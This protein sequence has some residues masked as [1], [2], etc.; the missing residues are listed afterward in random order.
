[1]HSSATV[2]ICE[3]EQA[4]IEESV[5]HE[6]LEEE[7]GEHVQDSSYVK[8][9]TVNDFTS[10]HEQSDKNTRSA[11]DDCV[12]INTPNN[13]HLVTEQRKNGSMNQNAHP[14]ENV[15]TSVLRNTD[16]SVLRNTDTNVLRNTDTSI[17]SAF[18]LLA[19]TLQEGF[20]LP[21]PELLRFS[22]S[23]LEYC[24]FVNN[25]ETNID[26]KVRDDRLRLS[27]LI[28]YCDGEAK[29]AIEDCV[30]LSP[31]EGY[32][33]ARDILYSRYGRPH[34][35]ARTYV[36]KI[37]N[38]HSLKAS[39][40]N[41]LSDLALEMRKCEITL[42][43]LGFKSDI[44]N[45]DNL[46]RIVRRLPMHVRGK[47]VDIAHSITESGREPGF[48]DLVKFVE[49]KARIATSLY[50]LDL[51]NEKSHGKIVEDRTFKSKPSPAPR[52]NNA[53]SFAT[54]SAVNN[55]MYKPSRKCYCCSGSC[56]DLASC[57]KFTA[58]NLNDR[59]QF[60]K[61]NRLCFNCLKGKHFSNVCRK[62][63]G[64]NVTECKS[65]HHFLLHSWVDSKSDHT[66][67]QSVVNCATK[68]GSY[69][70]NCL[71]IIPVLVRGK[72]GTYCKTYA[73]LDE[74]ADQTLCD[75][76]LLKML[77]LTSKPV[78]FKM[79]TASSSGIIVEGQEVE[80]HVQP[81]SGGNDVTL[82]KVWSVKSLPVSTRS[83]A[84]NADI[85]DLPY[86]SKI[87]TPEIDSSSVMLLI[88]TDAPQAHIPLE[89][90]SGRHDQPYAIKTQLG[91]AVRGPVT[92]TTTQKSANVNFQQ[93]ADVLLQQQLEKMWTT[94]FDDKVK[95]E[96]NSMSLEDKKALNTM[97]SSLRYENGHYKLKLPWRDEKAV[98]PNNLTLAH[99]RL[100]HLKRKLA[101]DQELH[102]MYTASV[103]DYIQ[104]GHAQEVTHIESDSNR[105]WYLPHHPVTNPN[106][107]GKVRV[108]FD[109]A[110]KY[111]G[112]SLNS[113]LLQGP[114]FM[115]SLVGVLIRFRQE[116]VAIAADIEAM[117]HQVR[118]EDLD[119]DA[120]RFLW[121]P[122]GDMTQQPRCYKMLVHLFG[123]TSSPSCTAY[124]LI[125]TASD[126]AHM[127]KP[128][129]VN[130]VKRNF[131]VDDCLKSVSSD[132]K[133]IELAADLQSLLRRGGFRL[134]K[135]L[136]NK[137]DV[138]ESIPESERA[139][140]IMNLSKS[141]SSP[142]DRALGVQWNVEKDELKFKVQL[143]EKPI[144]RR[145]I[146]SIVSSIFD[147]L[148]LVAP[149]TLRAKAIVQNLCRQKLSW[150]DP[151][152]E[153][154]TYEWKQWLDTLP[155]LES[156]SVRRCFKPQDF[157]TLK[158]AQLHTSIPRLELSGAVVASRLYTL[159]A[160]E[161]EINIDS[162]TFWT[163]SMIV[164]GYIKNENRRFKTFVGNRISEIHDV[165]S[166][167]Q[168][169][170]VDTASN[171]AD[172]ASRG[173]HA[174][175]FKTMKFWMHGPEFL[176]K[177]ESH[178]P[179][180]LTKP[181]LDDDDTELKKRG[182]RQHN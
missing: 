159:V 132:E 44:D 43:Q 73:L 131:Y 22:G 36:D 104:K 148:G 89:V 38:G 163:D 120:L 105:V 107:P 66:D 26:C 180:H 110:A 108:V 3:L 46:R 63:T 15:V 28:Q 48:S 129:V 101:R 10:G 51:A 171:P 9:T 164:L 50:G 79:S 72:S 87:E 156:V 91:W 162:V 57:T 27:Y 160:D 106:K 167:D 52:R 53:V 168:W 124:A 135:W 56:K 177:D 115:N 45:T 157:G 161:L 151:I 69:V 145:G 47:W 39:D 114:D 153:K 5:W 81:A 65:R 144:T 142:V 123:A 176:Q 40:T 96:R 60:V 58:M 71:G 138:V 18:Q 75:E 112:I 102:K 85:R 62:P 92:D 32:K 119:C 55:P 100:E 24:K 20:N 2:K 116:P 42:S 61:K 97:N 158:N 150:D 141:D 174:S 165:T 109:C 59:E 83:A 6:A 98:M 19:N 64:C 134:T 88:G 130:T 74:G 175:D 147:P 155:Y 80:L 121:W 169:R 23:T 54:N 84:K 77:N 118:V 179:S 94:D 133:A 136:S 13:T 137:R 127:Y 154:D 1:M 8:Q 82:R 86:L 4:R 140:S 149:V 68:S 25:F 143:S 166:R 111:K 117:F 67:Q 16:T 178:W 139:R 173:M 11:H 182:C 170:H 125:R 152:P 34:N 78:T 93:S 33:R 90:R 12:I 146:L 99:A 49:E 41:G 122:E 35:I 31:S 37:V 21:K 103:T 17:E 14:S 128:E 113:Q 126:N 7:T 29:S 172:V 70:K 30:L 181:E 76:R 95:V